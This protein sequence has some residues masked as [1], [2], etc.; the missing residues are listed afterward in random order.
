MDSNI[1]NIE[2]GKIQLTVE[3]NKEELGQYIKDTE[4]QLGRD[5]KL[6]G[7]RKGKAPDEL[8][9]KH[10]SDD[11]LRETALQNAVQDTLSK[12]ARERNLN[13][14]K[15]TDLK[16]EKNDKG[17]FCYS[18]VVYTMPEVVLPELS[19]FQERIKETS[20]DAK[21]AQEALDVVRNMKA[22][23]A[24]KDAPAENGDRVEVDFVVTM[25]GNKIEGGESKSHP[26]I[27]G[28][29]NFIP[30][31]EEQLVGTKKGEKKD[32][33]LTAPKDYFQETLAGKELDF[34]VTV[35]KVQS[36]NLPEVNDEFAKQVGRF[37][38]VDQLK[39]SI[40]EG[41]KQEK[42]QK[43]KQRARLSIL[44]Q[45]IK[46]TKIN[47]P[48]FFVEDNLDVMVENFGRDLHAKGMELN[49]YLARMNKTADDLRKDWHKE[50][51]RQAKISV[52]LQTVAKQN[53]ISI[54]PQEVDQ[55]LNETVQALV[56]RGQLN[57][58]EA[59]LQGIRSSI[60]SRL[61]NEKTLTFIESKC[62]KT[63]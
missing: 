41:I 27:I 38:N 11:Q 61:I 8:I 13:I 36:V 15:T 56:S 16:I 10:L 45:I 48:P 26:L 25:N 22:T 55:S 49:L 20:V 5:I 62:M 18:V 53:D 51:E 40:E 7:F 2:E 57:P 24:D 17:K 6:D 46:S 50:A 58:A 35:N 63:A 32:F 23:F 9:K 33:S 34:S 31:F 19:T 21:E 42:Q 44:D 4:K 29:K 1:K 60:A 30:G 37:Q 12:V 52:I 54:S 59:D 47:I 39:R 43:E 28:G 14:V 3:L